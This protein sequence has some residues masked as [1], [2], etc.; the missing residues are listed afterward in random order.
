MAIPAKVAE[1]LSLGLKRLQP[2]LAAARTKD[3]NESDTSRIVVDLLCDLFGFDRYAEV[4]SEFAIRGT[5][6]DLAIKLDG[7]LYLLVEV[8]AVG[9]ELKDSHIKQAIDYGANQGI[10]WVILTNAVS[11]RVY[12]VQYTKP[13]NHEMVLDLDLTS[14]SHRNS[15]HMDQLFLLCREVLVRSSL[16]EYHAQRQALNRFM[17]AGVIMSEPI[18]SAIR[19]ELRRLTPGVKIEAVEIET[20]LLQEILKREVVEGEKAEEARR[21]IN[22]S[23]AKVKK[24]AATGV[25]AESQATTEDELPSDEINT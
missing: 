16:T 4:T 23:L 14:V 7:K 5:Y 21:K 17:L 3:I 12:R 2:V 25:V 11:W 20:S 8:K 1:R 6:C 18:I 15:E 9:I 19:R 13:I 10:D 22:R 24:A